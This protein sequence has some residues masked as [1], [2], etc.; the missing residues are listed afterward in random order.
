MT[1]QQALDLLS[2][3][4]TVHTQAGDE[5]TLTVERQNYKIQVT[6]DECSQPSFK[7][8]E[9]G[10]LVIDT[11]DSLEACLEAFNA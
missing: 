6:L 7:A 3:F 9:D 4:G 11:R 1:T 10:C 5:T 2:P 8:W